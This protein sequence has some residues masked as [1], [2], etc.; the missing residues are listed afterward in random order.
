MAYVRGRGRASE[1]GMGSVI[2]APIRVLIIGDSITG[3][4]STN[5]TDNG[6]AYNITGIT[7]ASS[8]VISENSSL[9]TTTGDTMYIHS[10]KGMVEINNRQAIASATSS[11]T[12]T[13]PIDSTGFNTWTEDGKVYRRNNAVISNLA[14]GAFTCANALMGQRFIFTHEYNRGIGGDTTTELELRKEVSLSGNG[15]EDTYD[16]VVFMAGT[17]DIGVN[18]GVTPASLATLQANITSIVNYVTITLGKTMVL[19]TVPPV[20]DNTATQIQRRKDYNAWV[21]TL[22]SNKVIIWDYWD[23]VTDSGTD[24]WKSGY[25]YD[26]VHPNPFG[27]HIMGMRLRDALVPYYG[28]S[29]GFVLRSTN[30][31]TNPFFTGTGGTLSGA[32]A[33]NNGIA[34]GWTVET[35][36]TGA[37]G[38]KTLSK[39]SN[40]RQRF[41]A[42]YG[43]GL[44]TGERISAR[45]DV[46]AENLIVGQYYTCEALY[47]I[48]EGSGTWYEAS[49]ELRNNSSGFGF[50]YAR[51]SNDP[52]AISSIIAD[53]GYLHLKT[54]PIMFL[55]GW[56]ALRPRTNMT[57]KCNVAAGTG[58]IRLVACQLYPSEYA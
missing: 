19:G 25:A 8:A 46:A 1:R 6:T 2:T 23:A 4:T 17:N 37:A 18:S 34:T 3:A 27:S 39:D 43:S 21:R 51:R 44:S 14:Q 32:G 33:T 40:D 54:Q 42:N 10:V 16:L 5:S 20:D 57:H 48:V 11:T 9:S 30:L 24:D 36:G 38:T 15:F 49:L 22:A 12:V 7:K 31:L 55:S 52:L 47:Q 45:Q 41:V 53:G 29:S 13:V 56:T 28:R 50:D 35:S 26:G 58:D